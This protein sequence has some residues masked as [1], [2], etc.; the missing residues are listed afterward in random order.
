[1]RR[2]SIFVNHSTFEIELIRH[3]AKDK[4]INT[5]AAFK[6][7]RSM[8]AGL[9]ECVDRLSGASQWTPSIQEDAGY[10]I[11]HIEHRPCF[12]K[13]RYAQELASRVDATD[14]PRYIHRAIGRLIQE[15]GKSH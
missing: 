6:A 7:G 12:G 14:L 10:F 9:K 11:S 15:V 1:L 3:A 5:F 8:M 2:E 4:A 13:G